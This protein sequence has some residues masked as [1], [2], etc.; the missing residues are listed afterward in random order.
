MKKKIENLKGNALKVLIFIGILWGIKIF[1]TIVPIDL[2]NFGIVPRTIR[3]LAGI[4]FAPFLHANYFHLMSNTIPAFV[5]LLVLILFYKKESPIVIL[6]SIVMGGA[7]VWIFGRSASHV[8]ISGLIYSMAAFLI[9][10]G[11][12]KKDIKS[13]LLSIVII[14]LYGGL[15]WGIFPGRFWISWEGHFFGAIVGVVIAFY[16]FRKKDDNTIS[17]K[18]FEA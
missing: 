9:T 16:L 13:L 3:G 6:L 8:G 10:A 2:S 5:L 12:I 15:I 1:D 17:N 7:L 18:E 4:L 14:V 11:F